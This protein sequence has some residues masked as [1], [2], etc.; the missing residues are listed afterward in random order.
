MLWLVEPLLQRYVNPEGALSETEPPEQK[1]VGPPVVMFGVCGAW[2]TVTCVA[3]ET[4]EVQVPEIV[5]TVYEP[6][7][8][9][10]MLWLV[11]PLLQM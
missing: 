3:C 10:V 5:L 9:T 8:L 4:A 6:V 1:L 7:E 2:V 11:E